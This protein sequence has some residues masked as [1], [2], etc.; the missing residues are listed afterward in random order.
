MPESPKTEVKDTEGDSLT[1]FIGDQAENRR[2]RKPKIP[3]NPGLLTQAVTDIDL[4]RP[5]PM[6]RTDTRPGCH[7][8]VP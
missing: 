6:G 3:R 8:K 2:R 4:R 5:P 7:G 1:S